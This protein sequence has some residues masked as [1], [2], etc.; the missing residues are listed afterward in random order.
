M[1]EGNSV[2]VT[3]GA[4]FLGSHLCGRLLR[5]RRDVVCIDNFYTGTRRN[6]EHL[7]GYCNFELMRHDVTITLAR[8]GLG[9]EPKVGIE[10]GLKETVA[11]FRDLRS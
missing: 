5:E 4:G 10:D 11:Y 1:R 2:L 9:W 7:L 3:G 6:V 8:R